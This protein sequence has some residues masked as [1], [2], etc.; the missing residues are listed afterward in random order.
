MSHRRLQAVAFVAAVWILGCAATNHT[1]PFYADPAN[2]DP[3]GV[4][5]TDQIRYRLIL[6]GDAGAHGPARFAVLTR[7]RQVAEELPARTTTIFLGDNV[8]EHGI[9]KPVH[10]DYADAKSR[11]DAQVDVLARTG[12]AGPF[13]LFVPGNHD[14]SSGGADGQ[15]R[16][17]QQYEYVLQ[18]DFGSGLHPKALPAGGCP[19][20]EKLDLPLRWSAAWAPVLD[21]DRTMQLSEDSGLRVIAIDTQWWLHNDDRKARNQCFSDT[22]TEDYE[23]QF[24]RRLEEMLATA[25]EREVIVVAHHPLRSHGPHGGFDRTGF[26]FGPIWNRLRQI[27]GD[28]QDLSDGSEYGPMV[29]K[30]ERVLATGRPLAYAAG[31]EHNLQ[32]LDGGSSVPY[33][34]ISGSGS[35]L[36]AATDGKDTFFAQSAHGFMTVDLL[37]GPERKVA[38]RVHVPGAASNPVYSRWLRE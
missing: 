15:E 22:D 7:A 12:D 38:L 21:P 2:A 4:V 27:F 18:Q 3:V 25:G 23:D 28:R 32:V 19:G 9:P 13:G 35:K 8:Y 33:V 10:A 1:T 29:K 5:D 30:L 24:L 26:F 37:K 34:L 31:H 14:W 20:P 36:S 16:A 11:L 6:V 17:V